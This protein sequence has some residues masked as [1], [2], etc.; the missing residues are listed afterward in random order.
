MIYEIDES[1]LDTLYDKNPNSVAFLEQLA[2]DR[3][4]CKNII[5][6]KRNIFKELAK[7]DCFSL[8]T[9]DLYR[10]LS[11]RVSEHKLILESAKRYCRIVGEKIEDTIIFNEGKEIVI[12][13]VDDEIS[14]DFT[15]RAL[16][17]AE[18]KDDIS[19]YKILG[20]YFVRQ[21]KIGNIKIDFEICNGGGSTTSSIL[22][23]LI[24]ERN[25]MCLCMVDSDKKYANATPKETMQKV[26]EVIAGIVQDYFEVVFLDVHEI[27]NL[28]PISILERIVKKQNLNTQGI[29][30]MRFLLNG[31][32][33]KKSPI[34]YYDVKKGIPKSAYVLSDNADEKMQKD[35]RKMSNYRD[36]W[37][38][39][40]QGFG[41]E[42]E[43]DGGTVIEG[44]CDKVLRHTLSY[45]EELKVESRIEALSIDSYLKDIWLDIGE[46]VYCWGCVGNRIAM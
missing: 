5:I 12:L 23:S 10:I 32:K 13:K 8:V 2:L 35:Y 22:E 21:R 11:N 20:Q 16:M 33:T 30:F 41:A 24:K 19:F 38:P 43:Q 37:T 6:A 44:I 34:F 31:D 26:Q 4:K 9:K 42:I 29:E 45:F 7:M 15:N 27:E 1:C 14:T 18:N 25:R 3:R 17:L 36:Y 39:Y 40:I 28:I 46:K